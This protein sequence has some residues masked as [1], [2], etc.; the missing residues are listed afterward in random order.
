MTLPQDVIGVDVSK[1]WIDVIT[2]ST[3][4]AERRS[5]PLPRRKRLTILNAMIR[6][7]ANDTQRQV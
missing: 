6:D 1:D 2:L 7:G 4:R 5:V 3:G